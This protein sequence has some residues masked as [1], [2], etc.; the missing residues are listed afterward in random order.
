LLRGWTD[1]DEGPW[2]DLCADPEVM[3]HI[4]RGSTRTATE[5][6]AAMERIRTAWAT[7]GFGL[8]A[9]E[10]RADGEFLGFCGLSEPTFLPEV[11]PATEI[12]WRLTRQA[13][14]QGYATEAAR[15]VVRLAFD[16]V[17]LDRLLSI[18]QVGNEVSIGIMAKLGMQLW[19]RTVDPTC[20]RPVVVYELRNAAAQ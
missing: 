10:R 8:F 13:W 17:G 15:Q 6:A 20:D 5:S 7:R 18:A 11:L 4:A 12:G 3:R 16:H 9:V 14:G 2:A 1:A 19:R